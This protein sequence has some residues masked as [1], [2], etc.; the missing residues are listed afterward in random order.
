MNTD[1]GTKGNSESWDLRLWIWVLLC[2][3]VI[4]SFIPFARGIQKFVYDAAGKDFFTY[5]V[6]AVVSS[7]S[8]ILLYFLVFRLKVRKISPYIW[9]FICTGLY[10]YFTINLRDN[11]EEAIHLLEYGLLSYFVFR[12]LSARIR[13][14]SIYITAIFIV[15]IFGT[16]D[17]FIQWMLP[18]RYWGF[19]DVGINI[20]GG[21]ILQLA[22]WKG[23]RPE[24]ISRP[25]KKI[26]VRMLAGALTVNLLLLG[27]CLSNTP[28]TV[29]KYTSIL[30]GLSWLR[31]QEPMTEF[32]HRHED[33][34]IGTF[35][36]RFTLKEL[37]NIDDNNGKYLGS[38]SAI[39]GKPLLLQESSAM[40]AAYFMDE[41]MT[42]MSRRNSSFNR[43]MHAKD[44][45]QKKF[46]SNTAY[47][48]NLIL[49]KFYRNTLK[50][51]GFGW[52]AERIHDLAGTASLW[53]GIYESRAGN[54]ITLFSLRTAWILISLSLLTMWMLCRKWTKRLCD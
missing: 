7:G 19:R 13:D 21:A 34:G 40:N 46:F 41:F 5:F 12:A 44:Q 52:S 38:M 14:R 16:I 54:I 27:L 2:T 6:L 51:S 1:P 30:K 43:S 22:V 10:I 9:I 24:I 47:R 18:G 33:P 42:H 17:E 45:N 23:I 29:Y 25:L 26:S 36:S 39:N 28:Q 4:L 37:K 20:L 15:S 3:L 8:I 53:Q 48:E 49:E 11:P 32:G 31:D 50:H 35:Y